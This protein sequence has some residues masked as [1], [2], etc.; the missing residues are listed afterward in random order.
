MR[1]LYESKTGEDIRMKKF[2]AL[3]LAGMLCFGCISACAEDLDLTGMAAGI[4]L[5][6]GKGPVD[7]GKLRERTLRRA[8]LDISYTVDVTDEAVLVSFDQVQ[9][10]LDRIAGSG[11]LCLTADFFASI[12][13]YSMFSDPTYMYEE[14]VLAK[15]LIMYTAD[16]YTDVRSYLYCQGEDPITRLAGNLSKLQEKDQQ[17]VVKALGYTPDQMVSSGHNTWIVW[18]ANAVTIAG[19]KYIRLEAGNVES[20]EDM[21]DLLN[22][23]IITD[24]E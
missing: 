8:E 2:F 5:R 3:L 24:G 21:E 16:L 1:C 23:L 6:E 12:S 15:E 10:K 11:I 19:G 20:R 22:V 13:D 4:D 9:V 18:G 14:V 17:S 7:A